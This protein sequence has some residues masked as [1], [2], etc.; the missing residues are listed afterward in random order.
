M[1]DLA[2]TETASLDVVLPPIVHDRPTTLRHSVWKW[3]LIAGGAAIAAYFTVARAV[4]HGTEIVYFGIGASSVIGIIVGVHMH[5]PVRSA[6]WYLL[7]AGMTLWVIG[8]G[9]YNASVFFKVDV[10]Y[11][12]ASDP[13]FLMA[14][15]VLGVGLVL[16]QRPQRRRRSGAAALI[17]AAIITLSASLASW[18]LLMRPYLDDPT[19]TLLA[20]TVSV[21]YPVGDLILLGVMIPMIRS[22][23]R[24][25]PSSRFLMTW[26]TL[27]LVSDA[28]YS[29]MVIHGS[30]V[31]GAWIDGGWLIGY[32]VLAVAALHPSMA[33]P[34]RELDEHHTRPTMGWVTLGLLA[35]ASVA[36][37]ALLVIEAVTKDWSAAAV[38]AICC[39]ILAL[40][41]L[42]RLTGLVRESDARRRELDGTLEQ[43]SFQTLHDQLTGLAN[44]GLFAD[45]VQHAAARFTRTTSTYA[46]LMFDLDDFKE[47]NDAMGHLAGD[48]LLSEVAA[49]L[50]ATARNSDTVARLGGDEFAMLLEGSE[51]VA[52]AVRAAER[53]LEAVKAPIDLGGR[54]I[55]P[56]ASVGI[57]MH[58]PA[59]AAADTL[60]HADL[61]MYAAKQS[62]KGRAVVYSDGMGDAEALSIELEADMHDALAHDPAQFT[63]YYQP[64]VALRTGR[65]EALEALV[66][67]AHPAQGVILPERFIHLA[68]RTGVIVP[69]GR[70]I[71]REACRQ[72]AIWRRTI[73]GMETIGINVNLSTKQVESAGLLQTV[74][75]AL[76]CAQLE[77]EALTLE[78]TEDL[79]V[80]GDATAVDD[81][82]KALVALGVRLSIDDFGTGNASLAYLRRFSITELKID[83]S[84]VDGLGTPGE[85]P[86]LV[87]GLMDLGRALGLRI[88]AEGIEDRLE[89]CSLIEMGCD[90]GQGF[91][92]GRPLPADATTRVLEGWA[93][94]NDHVDISA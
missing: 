84:Y 89:L 9:I 27:L 73:A 5:H 37:P 23:Q 88:V 78:L 44:R 11:P 56:S 25:S 49:R 26:L 79:Q 7:A 63:V 20:R 66:R 46:V 85:R 34:H 86:E 43:L 40:L 64:I 53:A 45:R 61:A 18:V 14:Y 41:V 50:T 17:E 65:L 74:R 58:D 76:T 83:R 82:L 47:I 10:P 19:A 36:G 75:D 94:V 38:T 90:F 52:G 60:R 29:G 8:D 77:P 1:H 80:V 92:F 51:G 48:I 39:V 35:V 62:G 13:F 12:S 71:T 81:R 69:L 59:H 55:S 32:V 57:A 16:T 30:Y 6:P 15:P 72:A 87:R 67:W 33:S 4:P 2:A 28:I 93:E 54:T 24:R 91:L 70:L 31:D 3:W 68:E 22:G 21:S 42:L